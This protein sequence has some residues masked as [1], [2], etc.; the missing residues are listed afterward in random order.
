MFLDQLLFPKTHNWACPTRGLVAFGF[1]TELLLKIM[2]NTIF[3][4]GTIIPSIKVRKIGLCN[5]SRLSSI[6]PTKPTF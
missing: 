2:K 4:I 1:R 6:L 5:F 3:V